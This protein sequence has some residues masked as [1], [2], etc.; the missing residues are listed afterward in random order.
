MFS[1]FFRL[2]KNSGPISLSKNL[3][4]IHRFGHVGFYIFGRT[5]V[6]TPVHLSMVT[7]FVQSTVCINVCVCVCLLACICEHLA[8]CAYPCDVMCMM[9]GSEAYLPPSYIICIL[10][11]ACA[12]GVRFSDACCFSTGGSGIHGV[13]LLRRRAH[14]VLLRRPTVRHHTHAE[15]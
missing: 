3:N 6:R 5:H 15:S 1:N 11:T 10:V 2:S 4:N 12:L 8:I 13:L 7:I 9:G 14:Q